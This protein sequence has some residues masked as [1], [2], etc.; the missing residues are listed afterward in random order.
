MADLMTAV[1]EFEKLQTQYKDFRVPAASFTVGGTDL[2][3]TKAAV[4]RV[5]AVLNLEGASSVRI[6]FA[7]CYDVKNGSYMS[8]LKNAAIPGKTAELSLGYLSS[9]EKVFRGYLSGVRIAADAEEG[10]SMEFVA[11][12][13]RRLMMTDNSHIREFKITNYSDAVSEI[14]KRYAKLATAKVDSTGEQLKDGL[15][16][17][18]GSDYDFI[19]KDLIESGLCD[20]EFFAA[21]DNIYFRKPQSVTSPVISLRPGGGLVSLETDSEYIN[22]NFIVQGFDP[23]SRKAVSGKA[24]A[25]T[26]AP[27]NDPLGGPGEFFVCDPCCTSASAGEERAK[28]LARTALDRSRKA[29]IRCVGLPQLIPG[30]FLKIERVDA[31]VNRKYYITR[32]THTFDEDGFRTEAETEGWE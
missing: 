16:W 3:K 32:V 27:V 10:Y 19:R 7:D 2:T 1:W 22:T 13:V 18:N 25:K 20:R 31:A 23:A 26:A 5:E 8:E 30:R 9:L 12:D 21:V 29:T 11:L 17:Q 6:R 15:L 4:T 24:A 28:A 14:L